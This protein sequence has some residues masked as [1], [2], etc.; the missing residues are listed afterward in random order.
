MPSLYV[1]LKV[2]NI[3]VLVT[4]K[5]RKKKNLQSSFQTLA[6]LFVLYTLFYSFLLYILSHSTVRVSRSTF[7]TGSPS[8][9][10]ANQRND[11][12]P[13]HIWLANIQVTLTA[14]Y[15]SA[16]LACACSPD[17]NAHHRLTEAFINIFLKDI[18]PTHCPGSSYLR[19]QA[20]RRTG[21]NMMISI[22]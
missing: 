8:E 18:N 16:R 22:N 3:I 13:G 21:D 12:Y 10:K 19:I 15:I 9:S 14:R 17:Q 4:L 11:K 20:V 1:L 2:G 7:L 6:L 5:K